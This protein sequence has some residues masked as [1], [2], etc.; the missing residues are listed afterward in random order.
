MIKV[1]IQ[2]GILMNKIIVTGG[3]GFLGKSVCRRLEE[4]AYDM[5]SVI[6]PSSC[7]FDLREKNHC[8]KLFRTYNPD[9]IIHLAATCGG[10]GAN[11]N[12]PGKY[13]YDNISMGINVIESCRKYNVKK[14]ILVG[15][16]CSYPKYCPT[17][18]LEDSIWE[19]YP[20]ET[21]APYGIAKKSLY[22]ML[23]AYRQQY[24][25]N[26][27]VLIPTNLYGPEDNFDDNSS[28]V[29]P[30]LIKKIHQCKLNNEK[31]IVWGDGSA[32]RE[33]LYVEDAARAIVQGIDV[34]SSNIINLGSGEEISILDL[35][36]TICNIMKFDTSMI[37]WDTSKP[38]GQPKRML[39]INRAKNELRW[40]S[41]TTLL[42]G[43][44]QTIQWYYA[45]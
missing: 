30:A 23:D 31:L 3:N 21:N 25:L 39:N 10:I 38:N 22:V 11:R 4:C 34:D 35:V 13:F 1:S 6:K 18:F 40:E 7:Q 14:I 9:T 28:H 43:L 33:F 8:E 26:S 12:N 41:D 27:L 37:E 2:K 5:N 19:G 20:E 44:E 29:I 36:Y 24:G 32:T 17:P 16:V 45:R 15:T 42:K